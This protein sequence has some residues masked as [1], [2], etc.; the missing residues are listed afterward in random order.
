MKTFYLIQEV[1]GF[2]FWDDWNRR[3]RGYL[4]ATYFPTEEDLL[5]Y[6]KKENI[7]AFRIAKIYDTK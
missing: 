2:G 6:A 7:G 5:A 1:D 3:F 4:Y